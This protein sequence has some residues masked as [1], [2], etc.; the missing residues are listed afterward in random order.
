MRFVFLSLLLAL[1]TTFAKSVSA[2]CYAEAGSRY[3]VSPRLLQAIAQGES[4]FNP[5]AVNQNTNG[6][7]DFGLMQINS[8]WAPTLRRMGISWE[9]LADPCTNVMGGAWVLSRCIREFGNTWSA[10][11]CYNSRTP[12]R[13]D[14]YA[15]R[16]ARIVEREPFRQSGESSGVQVAAITGMTTPWEEA[17]GHAPR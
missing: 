2:F 11:G 8:S 12:S 17:F 6:S 1:S 10:V 9:S 16:I 15:A 3:G 5:V 13:R 7:Y 14:R 4:N